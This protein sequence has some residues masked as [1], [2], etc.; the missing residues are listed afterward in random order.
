MV[1]CTLSSP[2]IVHTPPVT[3]RTIGQAA[4]ANGEQCQ[5]ALAARP[6]HANGAISSPSSKRAKVKLSCA[7]VQAYTRAQIAADLQES[8]GQVIGL[9][10]CGMLAESLEDDRRLLS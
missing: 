9:A 3:I 5:F 6:H 2:T 4:R 1:Q 8:L 7:K 10:G